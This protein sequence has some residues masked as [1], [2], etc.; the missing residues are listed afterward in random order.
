[1]KSFSRS[2]RVLLLDDDEDDFVLIRDLLASAKSATFQVSWVP[3]YAQALDQLSEKEFDVV[4]ADFRLGEYDGLQ[5]FEAMRAKG[6]RQPQILLTGFGDLSLDQRALLS[7]ASDYLVKDELTSDLLERSIRY[8]LRHAQD[9]DAIRDLFQ[10]TFEGVLLEHEGIIFDANEAACRILGYPTRELVG[11]PLE[12]FLWL[13]ADLDSHG[14]YEVEATAST[15][16]RLPI[17]VQ[18]KRYLYQNLETRLISLRDLSQ[19]KEMEAQILRQDRLASIGLLGSSL[20]HEIGTPLGVIR[21]RA[22]YLMMSVEGD[23]GLYSSLEVIVGQIDRITVLIQS[24][25]SLARG[26]QGGDLQSVPFLKSLDRVLELLAHEFRKANITVESMHCEH[27][28]LRAQSQ[29]L[30]QVLLNL[31]VNSVH[32]IQTARKQ[33]IEREF[34]IQIQGIESPDSWEILVRDNGSGISEKNLSNLFK[35]FF[36]TKDVGSGT[37]LGLAT[38]F[39]IL[40]S[41]GGK[42]LVRSVE[43]EWTEFRLRVPKA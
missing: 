29:P 41:W 15:G 31:L 37:G 4:L 23:A 8:S 39:R 25:L 6:Y 28:V 13:K 5:F 35:P 2:I 40:E 11:K 17:E 1:M 42:I 9:L 18:T 30:E 14:S 22:E 43:G 16:E 24:L 21:G 32:A 38:C 12:E 33:G 19:R 20:A 3:G 26:D 34:K 36:T 7:G 10:A 27:V